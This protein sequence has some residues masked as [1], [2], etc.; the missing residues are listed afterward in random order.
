[1]SEK[2]PTLLEIDTTNSENRAY[3]KQ[4]DGVRQAAEADFERK[5]K[6][7][8]E[9]D[10]AIG[11]PN[12]AAEWLDRAT[13][14]SDLAS[15]IAKEHYDSNRDAYQELGIVTAHMAGVEINTDHPVTIG[16]PVQEQK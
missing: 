11:K 7:L 12:K 15:Q 16:V 13:E 5:T 1:M 2:A 8:T 14:N 6:D 10:F 9:V 4:A 3:L